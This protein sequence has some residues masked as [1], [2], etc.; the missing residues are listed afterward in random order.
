M[1]PEARPTDAATA[2]PGSDSSVFTG[3]EASNPSLPD[4]LVPLFH[5]YETSTIVPLRDAPFIILTVLVRGGWRQI[6][7]LFALYN[8]QR[9][10]AVVR[11]D[12]DELR[13]LP[14]VVANFWSVVFWRQPLRPR[15]LLQRWSLTRNVPRGSGK[16]VKNA[17]DVR[18]Y[19]PL[20]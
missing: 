13:T 19:Q 11:A 9:I 14:D 18:R 10:K 16:A 20:A 8:G 5:N 17:D 3:G 4:C 15:T 2:R 12:L 6:Q 7:A 1:E